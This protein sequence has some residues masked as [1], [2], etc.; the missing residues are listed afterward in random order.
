MVFPKTRKVARDDAVA[1]LFK[2]WRDQIPPLVWASG[3]WAADHHAPTR[4]TVGLPRRKRGSAQGRAQA[5]AQKR[6]LHLAARSRFED[7]SESCSTTE[8]C[9]PSA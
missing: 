8:Q 3:A 7:D 6:A 2:Q 1:C 9:L 5:T 4:E